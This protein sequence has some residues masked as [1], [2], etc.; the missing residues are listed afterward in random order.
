MDSNAVN[1]DPEAEFDNGTCQYITTL[2]LDLGELASAPSGP[3][4]AGSFQNWVPSSTPLTLESD[5]TYSVDV[6][7]VVGTQV[8]YKFI[9]GD[10]WGAEETVPVTCGAN[11]GLGG[12]NRFFIVDPAI[13]DVP[14]HCFSLCNV[15]GDP[16]YCGPGTYWDQE[17]SFCLPDGSIGGVCPEDLDG[18]GI[19]AVGDLL[20]ILSAFGTLCN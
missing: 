13:F 12:Y 5:G 6:I 20:L 2:H 7:A 16:G 4:I 11:N 3:H 8:D 14:I 1:Y 10:A 9:N 18:D 17:L 19:V 15:C